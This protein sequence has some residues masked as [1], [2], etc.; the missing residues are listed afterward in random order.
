MKRVV[1]PI[2]A[3][4][5]VLSDGGDSTAS[6]GFS[7]LNIEGLVHTK[8]HEIYIEKSDWWM[9]HAVLLGPNTV[10]RKEACQS[11]DATMRVSPDS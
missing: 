9:A 2:L 10:Y 3:G 11:N 5:F 1:N 4:T 8:R 6:Q 7:I